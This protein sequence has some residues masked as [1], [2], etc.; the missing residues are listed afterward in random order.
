MAGRHDVVLLG[1]GGYFGLATYGKKDDALG[2]CDREGCDEQG[3]R[4]GDQA[5][6][7]ATLATI[8]VPVGIA[9]AALGAYIALTA[10]SKKDPRT[11]SRLTVTPGGLHLSGSF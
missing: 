8:F 10:P 11:G 7:Y 4:D 9:V 1:V 3:K 6:T 2:H 5:H